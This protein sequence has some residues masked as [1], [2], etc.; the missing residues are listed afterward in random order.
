MSFH[1]QLLW[2]QRWGKGQ[3]KKASY[4]LLSPHPVSSAAMKLCTIRISCVH[5]AR[6]A[7]LCMGFTH[8]AASD[9]HIGIV[10]QCRPLARRD[11]WKGTETGAGRRHRIAKTCDFFKVVPTN[12]ASTVQTAQ[13]ETYLHLNKQIYAFIRC[14]SSVMNKHPLRL[15]RPPSI[16]TATRRSPKVWK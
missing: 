1:K 4:L 3:A 15:S 5:P 6:Q 11:S 9:R 8:S 16:F 2:R 12:S 10:Q 7:M 14:Q 13:D